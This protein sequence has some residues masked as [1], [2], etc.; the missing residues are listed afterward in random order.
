MRILK[1]A[2]EIAWRIYAVW[3]NFY[4]RF[5]ESILIE[6]GSAIWASEV[7]D[8]IASHYFDVYQFGSMNTKWKDKHEVS[9]F[10][11]DFCKDFIE[12]QKDRWYMGF[13]VCSHPLAILARRG[14]DCDDF[15][16]LS[17]ETFGFAVRVGLETYIFDCL[18]AFV[19][20]GPFFGH[21]V[22]VW[23]SSS[24]KV[25]VVNGRSVDFYNTRLDFLNDFR[26]GEAYGYPT[27]KLLAS[28][29]FKTFGDRI[30]FERFSHFRCE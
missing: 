6:K 23:R 5:F 13:D 18:R 26:T 14:G 12:Y 30:K 9:K 19:W 1:P 4:R 8:R 3:T 7:F 29:D 24:G 15:A 16:A 25:M 20:T 21:F 10:W 28:G 11:S 22:S 2:I 17:R 27:S